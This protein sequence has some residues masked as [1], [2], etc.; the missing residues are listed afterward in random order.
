MLD[1]VIFK[2]KRFAASGKLD[3]GAFVKT[4][5]QGTSLSERS[6]HHPSV[7]IAWPESRMAHFTR[8]CSSREG[9]RS[10]QV[11]FFQKLL[12]DC[13]EHP[14]IE[15]L[16]FKRH[17]SKDTVVAVSKPSSWL[18]LPFH[19][20]WGQAKIARAI[21]AVSFLFLECEDFTR[22]VPRISWCNGGKHL[23]RRV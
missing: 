1:M 9:V 5:H 13:P 22:F 11:A 19:P 12:H 15:E 7:H 4:T 8:I 14:M 20:C 10:A 6:G 3:T 2:G 23:W 17:R 21:K 18:V 16:C